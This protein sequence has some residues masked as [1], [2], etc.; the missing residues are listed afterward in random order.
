MIEMLQID[1]IGILAY[2][3]LNCRKRDEEIMADKPSI[4]CLD[5]PQDL[6]G[7]VNQLMAGRSL[8]DVAEQID[9]DYAGRNSASLI[10]VFTK[11]YAPLI[12]KCKDA[13]VKRLVLVSEPTYVS[14]V[15]DFFMGL[16]EL[17]HIHKRFRDGIMA[18]RIKEIAAGNPEDRV[19]A[20]VEQSSQ[21][22]VYEALKAFGAPYDSLREKRLMYDGLNAMLGLLEKEPEGTLNPGKPGFCMFGNDARER[23]EEIRRA[24]ENG[25]I[26]EEGVVGKLSEAQRLSQELAVSVMRTN[27]AFFNPNDQVRRAEIMQQKQELDDKWKSGRIEEDILVTFK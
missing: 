19:L 10:Q 11:D 23:H 21:L 3:I 2:D 26:P 24:F 5:R 6:Q 14:R 9:E 22:D 13:G 8:G 16:D 17:K 4:I 25:E 12:A 18:G 7:Y 20:A 27:K 15:V 1:N